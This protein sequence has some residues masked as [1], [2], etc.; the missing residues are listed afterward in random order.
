MIGAGVPGPGEPVV[1]VATRRN[2]ATP[3]AVPSCAAVLIRPD[4]VPRSASTVSF[5]N[6]VAATD[7]MPRPRPASAVQTPIADK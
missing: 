2:T 1:T 3:M 7:E 5:P 4:A 6:D